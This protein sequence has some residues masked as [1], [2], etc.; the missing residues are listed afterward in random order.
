VRI[1]IYLL[2]GVSET[3]E[4]SKVCYVVNTAEV[5]EK[6]QHDLRLDANPVSTRAPLF[7][8]G[9]ARHFDLPISCRIM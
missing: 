7:I 9:N 6:D 5:A 1:D 4:E 2:V 8:S 3:R